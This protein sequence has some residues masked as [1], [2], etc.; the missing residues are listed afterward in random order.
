MPPEEYT[1]DINSV[2]ASPDFEDVALIDS[3]QDLGLVG[4]SWKRLVGDSGEWVNRI[5][6]RGSDKVSS[7]GEAFPRPGARRHTAR[8]Y[9]G[10]RTHH[11]D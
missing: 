2:L 5:Y 7:E 1:R 8:R 3:E 10:E 4:L 9:S 6:Y 11:H